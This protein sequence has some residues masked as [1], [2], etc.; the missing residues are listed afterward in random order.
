MK[1]TMKVTMRNTSRTRASIDTFESVARQSEHA[2]SAEPE[3]SVVIAIDRHDI[4]GRQPV[5]LVELL[6]CT[7]VVAPCASTDGADPDVA[8]A[9]FADREDTLQ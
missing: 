8:V 9:I 5:V 1:A 6:Q 3:F 7:P 4:R 2:G